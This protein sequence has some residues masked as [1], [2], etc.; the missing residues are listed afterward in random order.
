[1]KKDTLIILAMLGRIEKRIR[2]IETQL[3]I[4]EVKKPKEADIEKIEEV[5]KGI[6]E[7][8]PTIEEVEKSSKEKIQKES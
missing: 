1:M 6:D 5:K 2:R 4:K 3:E 7:V 8:Y